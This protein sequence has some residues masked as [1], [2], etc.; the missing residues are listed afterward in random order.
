VRIWVL[1]PWKKQKWGNKMYDRIFKCDITIGRGTKAMPE[2]IKGLTV[3]C[4]NCEWF[5]PSQHC[6]VM[7]SQ[8]MNHESW[9]ATA[10]PKQFFKPKEEI[11]RI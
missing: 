6:G 8:R 9:C 3:Q 7:H 1:L 5:S 4:K 2:F 10:S 11:C